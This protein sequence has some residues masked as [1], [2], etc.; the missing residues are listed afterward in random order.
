MRLRLAILVA[1]CS[2]FV[3]LSYEIVWYRLLAVMTRGIASTFGLLLAAYLLGLAIGSRA[4]AVYCREKGGDVR[5]LRALAAFVVIANV[6]GSLVGPAFAWSAHFTDFRLGL[7]VVAISAAFLGAILPLVCHFG[8]DADDRAGVRLSYVYLANIIGSAAGSL[9][10]GF[11]LMDT[12]SIGTIAI[13]LALAGFALAAL[14]VAMSAPSRRRS[15]ASYAVLAGC[16][17]VAI[18]TLP[19]LN[20]RL[21]E[22]LIYKNEYDGTQRFAQVVETRSGVITVADDGSVYGGGA[23]DGVV[24]TSLENNDKNG[25]VRA[26]VIGA[27][28]P[29]PRDLLMVGLASGSWAQVAAN[30]PGVERMTIIEINPGYIEVV[31]RHPEVASLL[32]NPKV[33]IVFDDGRRWLRRHPERRFDVVVMNTTHHWRSHA[34]NI[35]SAEFMEMARGHLLPGGIFYFNTTDSYDVQLTAA[36]AYPFLL[37]ITNFVVVSD[38]LFRFDRERWRWLLATMRIDDKPVLDL[39]VASQKAVYDDLMGF[40]DIEGRESIFERTSKIASVITDDNMVPEWR[41]P[42]RYPDLTQH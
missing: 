37:R 28:H 9:L 25:I 29:K 18:L 42:L 24:N 21:Y 3:A 36:T 12:L 30:L 13:V 39:G 19:R 31:K 17:I 22:R 7:A 5:Q 2:G 11:V 20:D 23:Y 10:T 8:I 16:A 26:Y 40:N 33:T 15:L 6:I 34:T 1:G 35:L 14:L 4:V 41:E 32:Q 27:L 38:S